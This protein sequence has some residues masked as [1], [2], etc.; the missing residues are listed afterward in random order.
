MATLVL[1]QIKGSPITDSEMDANFSNLNRDSFLSVRNSIPWA[2]AT[3]FIRGDIINV[4]NRFYLVTNNGT[5][6]TTAPSHT[7]GTDA[8]GTV[9]LQFT[10]VSSYSAKDVLDKIKYVDGLNSGLDSDLLRGLVPSSTL[11][12]GADKS[13][14]VSRDAIGN[15]TF[16]GINVGVLTPTTI[17]ASNGAGT[18]GQVLI[19]TVTGIQWTTINTSLTVTNET[20]N[21]SRFIP[22]VDGV[23]SIQ[24]LK[25]NTTGIQY[26]PSTNVLSVNVSGNLTGN[27]TGNIS[28]VA[29]GNPKYTANTF[30]G[31]QTV[32]DEAY[33]ATTWND[34]L[35]VPTKNAIRDKIVSIDDAVTALTP[36]TITSDPTFVN[37]S[38]SPASTNWVKGLINTTSKQWQDLTTSRAAG[39]V[40]TAPTD[41]DIDVAI[42]VQTNANV[43]LYALLTVDGLVVYRDISRFGSKTLTATIPAGKQYSITLA[44]NTVMV[45]WI[46]RR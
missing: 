7:S 35:T 46:E 15:A 44:S 27:V 23:G 13:S 14:I 11:P 36:V 1:R 40:Y 29:A 28:G 10:T 34:N 39:V 26:N 45:S 21:N 37:N 32:P 24:S 5:T 19:S 33:D 25:V 16:N 3:S 9:N 43:D 42:V 38:N 22:F 18:L 4:A 30:T 8:N 2:P 20:A 12:V 31:H 41:R 17:N 6:S